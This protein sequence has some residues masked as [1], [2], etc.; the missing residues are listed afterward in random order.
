M[1]TTFREL[2]AELRSEAEGPDA[3]GFVNPLL[4]EIADRIGALANI[5]DATLYV[6]ISDADACLYVSNH[7]I[8]KKE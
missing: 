4:L 7:I 8:G 1:A 3:N 2:E 6:D 5:L